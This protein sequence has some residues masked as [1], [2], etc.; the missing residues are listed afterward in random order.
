[1]EH[2][3]TLLRAAQQGDEAALSELDFD[4]N[5]ELNFTTI[6]ISEDL[7]NTVYNVVSMCRITAHLL[8]RDILSASCRFLLELLHFLSRSY[9][10]KGCDYGYGSEDVLQKMKIILDQSARFCISRGEKVETSRLLKNIEWYQ[11]KVKDAK[12]GDSV[13]MRDLG[14]EELPSL[15]ITSHKTILPHRE[16][17]VTFRRTDEIARAAKVTG[18]TTLEQVNA[19]T[20]SFLDALQRIHY[21]NAAP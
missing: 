9:F 10:K 17:D 20:L 6:T 15:T 7:L 16:L 4:S 19:Y 21:P 11:Q 5:V 13:C 12:A 8:Q 2:F 1:M 3:K 14:V 18:D